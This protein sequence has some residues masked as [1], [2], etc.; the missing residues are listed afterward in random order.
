[1]MLQNMIIGYLRIK[2]LRG[3]WYERAAW[4]IVSS[5]PMPSSA[6][7]WKSLFE[8]LDMRFQ[9]GLV[10]GTGGHDD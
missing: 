6:E 2:G 8:W 7:S 4:E 3:A 10:Y 1:M 5:Y 9:N